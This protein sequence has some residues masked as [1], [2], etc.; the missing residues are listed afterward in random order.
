MNKSY[1]EERDKQNCEGPWRVIRA[2]MPDLYYRDAK[3]EWGQRKGRQYE[4]PGAQ[5]L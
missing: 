2:Y 3:R 4:D 5:D 1:R